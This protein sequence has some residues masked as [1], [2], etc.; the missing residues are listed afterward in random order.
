[1]RFF[2]ILGVLLLLAAVA[3]F[4]IFPALEHRRYQA[5]LGSAPRGRLSRLSSGAQAL[6]KKTVSDRAKIASLDE[7]RRRPQADL[8]AVNEL[9]AA[10]AALDL[11]ER[12]RDLSRLRGSFRE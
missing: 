2:G 9:D 11:D 8:D 1:M 3:V 6:E 10:D 12:C 5:D 7:F 4:V